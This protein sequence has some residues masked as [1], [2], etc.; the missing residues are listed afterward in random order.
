[1]ES[2]LWK[3]VY[4]VTTDAGKGKRPKRVQHGD[5]TVVLT[6]LWAVLHDRPVSWACRPSSWPPA[7]YRAVR[8]SPATMSRRLRRPSVK[9]LLR[10]VERR[11]RGRFGHSWCKWID[12]KPLPVGGASHDRHARTGYGNGGLKRGY[13][14]YAICDARGAPDAWAVLPMNMNEKR[15]ARHLVRQT[16]AEAYLVG[17]AQY[18]SS[19]LYDVANRQGFVLMAP[20]QQEGDLGHHYQSPHRR[21]ALELLTRPF[22]QTLMHE[23]YAIDRYFGT[24]TSFG[25]GL[26]PLPNWV[27]TLPRV[28]LWVQGKII[29]NMIRTLAHDSRVA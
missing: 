6:Y 9:A 16:P 4:Q 5:I 18:D 25:G 13:K 22:G 8:P 24:L 21:R 15:V 2:E 11:L 14:L 29:L 19:P 7:A 12:A 1:M 20:R 26:A 28:R 10:E 27:R 23:R 17:D 3:T